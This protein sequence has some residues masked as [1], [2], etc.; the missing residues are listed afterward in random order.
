MY[1]DWLPNQSGLFCSPPLT[2]VRLSS[3][4][5]DRSFC[6]VTVKFW[7]CVMAHHVTP[8]GT[9]CVHREVIVPLPASGEGI[10]SQVSVE[11]SSKCSVW[12]FASH[13][14]PL[15]EQSLGPPARAASIPLPALVE[16][17]TFRSCPLGLYPN[18]LPYTAASLCRSLFGHCTVTIF[19]A[20]VAARSG[21]CQAAPGFPLGFLYLFVVRIPFSS[22]LTVSFSSG[23]FIF[24]WPQLM[25]FV[26]FFPL[27]FL[28]DRF[29]Y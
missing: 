19:A 11:L 21:V 26:F 23:Y 3:S 13:P 9:Y 14:C 12:S 20:S 16:A 27:H 8:C 7:S 25:F 28:V 1:I 24:L 10:L 17:C 2:D 6:A 29:W 5:V 22:F 4:V 18:T 15:P